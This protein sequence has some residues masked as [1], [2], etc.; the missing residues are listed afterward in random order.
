MG[1]VHP[2]PPFDHVDFLRFRGMS[3]IF[4]IHWYTFSVNENSRKLFT[5]D[6]EAPL[7]LLTALQITE[8]LGT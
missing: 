3:I 2:T 4:L 1:G 7:F 8:P 5:A 6:N